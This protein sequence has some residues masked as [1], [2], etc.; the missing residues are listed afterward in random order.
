MDAPS[1]YFGAPIGLTQRRDDPERPSLDP[2]LQARARALWEPMAVSPGQPRTQQL[3]KL[4]EWF[5]SFEPGT[6][7]LPGDDP[8]A[9]LVLA[10]KGVCRHRALGF[11]VMAH[12]LGIPAHY[13]MNDAHAFI[14]AWTPGANGDGAARTR[15]SC[16]RRETSTCTSRPMATRSRGRPPIPRGQGV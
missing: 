14:E 9:D 8:L 7:G 13:V 12:S 15:S 16:T 4:T 2:G 3:M 1:D 5:R 6:P 10:Q 11:L